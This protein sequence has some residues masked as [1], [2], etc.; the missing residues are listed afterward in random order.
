M[1]LILLGLLLFLRANLVAEEPSVEVIDK[2]NWKKAEGFVPECL[3]EWVKNGEFILRVAPLTYDP[4]EHLPSFVLE[5]RTANIGKYEL[6]EKD[7]IVDVKTGKLAKHIVGIPFPKV[8]PEDPK[9]A[10]KIIYNKHYVGLNAG[11]KRFTTHI[12]WIGP[13]GFQREVEGLFIEAYLTGFPGADTYP[14]PR[15]MERYNIITVKKPYDLAGTSVM[16]WRYLSAK[17]DVNFS[18][19]PAIRRVRRTTPA[20]RSDGFLGSDFAQD[21]M[22]GYDGKTPAFEWKLIGERELLA[23]YA[24]PRPVPIS[25]TQKG[26]WVMD[27]GVEGIHYAYQE[28]GAT[29]AAWCPMNNVYVKRPAW[30]IEAK[31]KDPYYNYGIQYLWVDKEIWWSMYKLVHTRA[32]KFWKFLMVHQTGFENTATED[33]IM[34]LSDHLIVDAVRDHAT[35]TKQLHPS[36]IITMFA[37]L[38]LHDFT[39]GGFQKYCK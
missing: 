28:E 14:N 1:S 26:E 16:L 15:D 12:A 34:L 10:T 3:L 8:D 35:Y 19:V 37:D 23:P 27:R 39:L 32:N 38:D 24:S 13:S 31:S 17:Q 30:L 25:R 7:E 22:A 21:D 20:N 6:N 11:N 18:Y 29:V 5:S 36:A 9:A 33:R 2:K 4:A